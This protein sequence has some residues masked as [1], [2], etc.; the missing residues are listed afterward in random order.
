MRVIAENLI[1]EIAA[2]SENANFPASHL[3]DEH[4]KRLWKA[5]G[6]NQARLT[7]SIGAN[8]NCIA[9]FNTNAQRAVCNISDP[10]ETAWEAG[11]EWET[12]TEWATSDIDATTQLISIRDDINALWIEFEGSTIPLEADITLTNYDDTV[13]AGVAV[14]GIGLSFRD[15]RYGLQEGLVDRSVTIEM[16]NGSFYNHPRDRVRTF[17]GEILL[18]RYRQYTTTTT[19]TAINTLLD[20]GLPVV[21]G[22]SQVTDGETTSTSVT[23]TNELDFHTFMD[24]AKNK[25]LT[26]LAWKVTDENNDRWAVYARFNGMPGGSHAHPHHCVVSLSLI[27]VL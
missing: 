10:N 24:M 4:P 9:I 21:D 25:G 17:S 7:L 11:T 27:E 15:P 3:L 16:S 1:T 13:H 8:T 18:R 20:G 23:G 14:G 12:G 2:S 19:S 6:A 22:G 26:P 5:D